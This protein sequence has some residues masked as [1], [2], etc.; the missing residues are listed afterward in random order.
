MGIEELIMSVMASIVALTEL[1]KP[2]FAKLLPKFELNP[3]VI[4]LIAGGIIIAVIVFII[5]P[6]TEGLT[7]ALLFSFLSSSGLYGWAL[8][9]IKELYTELK[10]LF[11]K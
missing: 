2:I 9:P 4:Q 3:K 7:G 11:G 8:K 1:L 6:E 10:G 5:K